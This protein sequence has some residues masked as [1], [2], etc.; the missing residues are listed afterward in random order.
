MN[1]NDLTAA[2]QMEPEGFRES[3][4]EPARR[5]RSEHYGSTIAVS[6]LLAVSNIC[7]NRCTYCGLRAPNTAVPRYRLGLDDIKRSLEGIR[8]QGI[9]RLFLIS[10]EDPG[11]DMEE[12]RRAVEYA[13]R[14]GFQV[15]LGLGVLD[16]GDYRELRQTGADLYALKFETS[17]PRI[18][19]AVKP[20]ISLEERLQAIDEVR[21]AGLE[22]GS[23]NIVGLPGERIEDLAADIELMEELQISWAP[24]VPY[25]PAPNTPLGENQPMGSVEL[26]LREIALVRLALPQALITAGQPRQGSDLGFADP[27]GTKEA[28]AAGA[29]LL[30]V[31]LTPRDRRE[32]FAI[33]PRR[34]LPRLEEIDALLA[35][36]GLRR[37]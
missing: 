37:E 6:G 13:V 27:E 8:E 32:D 3:Y 7:R 23:G 5:A 17:N 30:F 36:L 21:E 26:L 19:S 22:L 11:L 14:L 15:M 12:M 1:R 29:N 4:F 9:G 10:G 35:E 31:D 34:I 18:F 28:L 2:L 33:T 20:D 25:L 24:I 16:S